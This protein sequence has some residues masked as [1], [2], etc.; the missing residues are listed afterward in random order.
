VIRRRGTRAGHCRVQAVVRLAVARA[1][2]AALGASLVWAGPIAAAQLRW[3]AAESDVDRALAAY[4]TDS[5]I[6]SD[7]LALTGRNISLDPELQLSIGPDVDGSRRPGYTGEERRIWLPYAYFEDVVRAQAA[8]GEA[9]ASPGGPGDGADGAAIDQ[10]GRAVRD[11]LDMLEYTLYHLL[12]HALLDNASASLDRDAE[13]I[14]AWLMIKGWPG[15]ALQWVEAARAFGRASQRL[16]SPARDYWHVHALYARDERRHLCWALG[17][18]P[19]AVEPLM[20]A[21]LN[22]AARRQR[23]QAS[24]YQ[25][26]ARMR[27]RLQDVLL[28]D[29]PLNAPLALRSDPGIQR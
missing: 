23:C 20:D 1:I 28:V 4:L 26:D 15:G 16:D 21:V 9:D 5:N 3:M 2:A 25:L 11:A 14:S 19:V 8:L 7:L 29:A 13:A 24:W 18:D 12:A 22:A 6:I 27:E 17:A 10:E